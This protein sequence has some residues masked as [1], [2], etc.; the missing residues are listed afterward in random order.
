MSGTQRLRVL[1]TGKLRVVRR[2]AGHEAVANFAQAA[3]T[4]MPPGVKPAV[5]QPLQAAKGNSLAI[6][7][8]PST[9]DGPR[10]L[11]Q[12]ARALNRR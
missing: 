5:G 6:H 12:E 10:H 11:V 8:T 1:A 3:L 9:L 2:V 7:R 4:F